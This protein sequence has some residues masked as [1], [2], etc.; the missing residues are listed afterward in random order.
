M[1]YSLIQRDKLPSMQD[2]WQLNNI[3]DITNHPS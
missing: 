1:K 3:L 2:R